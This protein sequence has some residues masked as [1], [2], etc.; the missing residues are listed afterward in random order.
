MESSRVCMWYVA[1]PQNGLHKDF[2]L[3]TDLL[4]PRFARE[5]LKETLPEDQIGSQK[6]SFWKQQ[7]LQLYMTHPISRAERR[8]A[9]PTYIRKASVLIL[10]ITNSGPQLEDLLIKRKLCLQAQVCLH[11]NGQLLHLNSTP[12]MK[13]WDLEIKNQ[14]KPAHI[15]IVGSAP[16]GAR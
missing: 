8:E 9:Q 3:T 13:F 10:V 16:L 5:T 7:Q 1:S 2:C 11:R 4:P 12:L 15:C 14:L 6:T